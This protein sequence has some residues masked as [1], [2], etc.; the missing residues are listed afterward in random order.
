MNHP[1]RAQLLEAVLRAEARALFVVDVS[2]EIMLHNEAACAMMRW[3]GSGQH[4]T[5]LK[6]LT[7]EDARER[8]QR[9]VTMVF[10]GSLIAG[11]ESRMVYPDHGVVW[12]QLDYK[13]LRGEDDQ[14]IGAAL[15]VR[16]I[17]QQRAEHERHAQV[18]EAET[19]PDV[20]VAVIK[21]R[22]E[23][24]QIVEVNDGYSQITGIPR[25]ALMGEPYHLLNGSGDAQPALVRL[26]DAVRSG[27]A[28]HATLRSYRADESVFLDRVTV[29]P[30]SLD[31]GEAPSHLISV[32]RNT[33][34][35]LEL[36]A[37]LNFQDQIMRAAPGVTLVFD[38]STR[39]IASFG[40]TAAL[41]GW[42]PEQL[43]GMS[44]SELLSQNDAACI[45]DYL[46]LLTSG[47]RYEGICALNTRSGEPIPLALI[48]Q[49]VPGVHGA[50]DRLVMFCRDMRSQFELESQLM[51]MKHMEHIGWMAQG[52]VHDLNHSITLALL[53]LDELGELADEVSSASLD[54]ARLSLHEAA[55][56]SRG[57][58][59]F[60]RA[61]LREQRHLIELDSWLSQ[62][63]RAFQLIVPS[64]V[65]LGT[66]AA[67]NLLVR[68]VTARLQQVLF[69]L[70]HNA[71]HALADK[72]PPHEV[73]RI[74]LGCEP[75]PTPGF[76]QIYVEDNG[77]G[78]SE[79]VLAQVF[80]P[81]Y[82]TRINGTGLGLPLCK[83]IVE[84]WGGAITVTSALGVGTRVTFTIPMALR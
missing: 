36:R 17:T 42:C 63:S 12:W 44:A 26:R 19:P 35:E 83:L 66:I 43:R 15:W 32:H 51:S 6:Q 33:T 78:M 13:P 3:L 67:P 29:F 68:V 50:L 37:Q 25:E 31:G 5:N 60:A 75:A 73:R 20:G 81:F 62:T 72:T 76:A 22:D 27:R 52:L 4:I 65:E 54:L 41:L 77:C 2:C 39:V 70:I 8:L 11:R 18:A 55:N 38:L 28:A 1:E 14:I 24:Y 30:V 49:L 56:L 71:A 53:H 74:R 59:Q 47:R 48:A 7:P 61:D 23:G 21:R 46:G 45:S 69:N 57:V 40:D 34:S 9:Y 79:E 82:T 64:G 80:T 58:L 16:D 84:R 10:G